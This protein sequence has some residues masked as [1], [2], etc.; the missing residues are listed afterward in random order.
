MI[1]NN[2]NINNYKLLIIILIINNN[3]H[4]DNINNLNIPF[5]IKVI[6]FVNIIYYLFYIKILSKSISKV[7]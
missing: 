5:Y 2:N 1:I 6:S 3:K 4:Y 7:I